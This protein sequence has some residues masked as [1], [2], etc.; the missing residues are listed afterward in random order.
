MSGMFMLIAGSVLATDLTAHAARAPQGCDQAG[1]RVIRDAFEAWRTGKGSITD[2][3]A[4]GVVWRIEGRSAVSKLYRG[5]QQFVDEVYEPFGARFDRSP[6]PFRPT[7]VHRIFCDTDTMIVYWAGRGVANDGKPYTN[8]YVWI[9][10]V[11]AG[12]VVEGV[13][14]YD[15]VA[16]DDLWRRVTPS[17]TPADKPRQ[18]SRDA[19]HRH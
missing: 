3:F 12:K 15:T 14:F 17:T 5:K 2:V 11:R 6:T 16:F 7:R 19:R 10:R 1:R 9:M 4:P 18:E 13:A 8:S